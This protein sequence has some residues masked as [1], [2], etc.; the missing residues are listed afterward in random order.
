MEATESPAYVLVPLGA[1]EAS[2][3]LVCVQCAGHTPGI[4][5]VRYAPAQDRLVS[6]RVSREAPAPWGSHAAVSRRVHLDGIFSAD[7]LRRMATWLEQESSEQ[8]PEPVLMA[9]RDA[10]RSV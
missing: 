5:R 8:A 1:S 4:Y 3:L 7:D 2:G 9:Q 10:T 6:V